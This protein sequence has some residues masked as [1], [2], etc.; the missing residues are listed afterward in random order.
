MIT[1]RID[2]ITHLPPER[3]N[4]IVPAPKSVKI[5]L[6]A[7]CNFSCSFCARGDKLRQQGDMDREFYNRIIREMR[8]SGVEELGLFYL[9]ESFLCKWLPDAIREAKEAGYPYVFLTTNG[10][11]ATAKR[12]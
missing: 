8:N 9:G 1:D 12:T 6:T 5:E 11:L 7:R 3:Y 2:A 4:T 10:S